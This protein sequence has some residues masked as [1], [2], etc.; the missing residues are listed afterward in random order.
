MDPTPLVQKL[1][2]K[3]I[4]HQNLVSAQLT[5]DFFWSRG[6]V[7]IQEVEMVQLEFGSD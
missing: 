6:Q 3:K 2:G 5:L 1:Y 4:Q 7:N